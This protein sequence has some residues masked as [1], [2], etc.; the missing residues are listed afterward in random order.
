VFQ[1]RPGG[2]RCAPLVDRHSLAPARLDHSLEWTSGERRLRGHAVGRGG[3]VQGCSRL[4]GDE[5]MQLNT[6]KRA[7]V[8]E[9]SLDQ[10]LRA[11]SQYRRIPREG[12]VTLP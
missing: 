10:Y 11:I 2:A 4:E 3:I 9:G 12:E 8:D 1:L 5:A 6:A 7:S